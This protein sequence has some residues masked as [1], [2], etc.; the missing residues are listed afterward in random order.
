MCMSSRGFKLTKLLNSTDLL[1][2]VVSFRIVLT[3]LLLIHD[4]CAQHEREHTH[5]QAE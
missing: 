4:V 2:T 3:P 5:L 1:F